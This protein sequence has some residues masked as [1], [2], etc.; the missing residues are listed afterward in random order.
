MPESEV[1]GLAEEFTAAV[2]LQGV[3]LDYSLAYARGNV[4]VQDIIQNE[5]PFL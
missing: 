1:S 3:P 2:E 4:T 5:V